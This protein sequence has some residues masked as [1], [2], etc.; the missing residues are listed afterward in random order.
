MAIKKVHLPDGSEVIIDE[1]LH[2]PQYSVIEFGA[3]VALNLRAFT[4]VQGQNVPQQ[5]VSPGGARTATESDTNQVSR[6]RMNHDEAYLAYAVTYEHFALSDATIPDASP[7]GILVAPAPVLSSDNLRR[8]QRDVVVEL[9]IG[10]GILKPQFR[11]PFSWIGQSVGAP[12]WSSGDTLAAG[13]AFSYGTAGEMTAKNQRRWNLPIF[14]QSDRVMFMQIKSE[15]GAITD[16]DQAVRLRWYL[17]GLKRR[18]V[19]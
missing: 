11:S 12:A 6:T 10:A 16:L 2:W 15:Q 18:P 17:D 19:A 5:G 13:I 8:L 1:W 7:G 4:Y 3:G 14:I 9:R